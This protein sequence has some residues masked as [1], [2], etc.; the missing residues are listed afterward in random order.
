[1]RTI[2]SPTPHEPATAPDDVIG[3]LERHDTFSSTRIDPRRVDVWLPPGYHDRKER[4]YP[5]LYTHDGQ[6]L[7]DPSLSFSGVA[8]GVDRAVTQLGQT[9]AAVDAIVVGIWNTPKRI[10]EY[11]PQKPLEEAPSR[12]VVER[13]A[14]QFGGTPVSDAYL[15]FVVWELK[16]FVDAHYRTLP[17][18][19]HTHVMGSSMGALISLYALCEYPDVFGGAACLSP[20]WTVGGVVMLPYLQAHLP[21]PRRH[22]VYFDYGNEGSLPMYEVCQ[23]QV[24]AVFLSGGYERGRTLVTRC[25]PGADHSERAWSER[26]EVPLAFLLGAA[27][28]AASMRRAA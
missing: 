14:E 12:V 15:S 4:R 3:T 6:N 25:F 23:R 10:L 11:M 26:V 22:R 1:M 5:V 19:A 17:D 18:A 7:F 13:F 16:P 24:D 21:D 9:G 8:W 27:R 28:Q 2:D 20:S